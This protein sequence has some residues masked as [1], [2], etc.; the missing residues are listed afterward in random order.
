[1]ILQCPECGSAVAE[2][3]LEDSYDGVVCPVC[4]AFI[5]DEEEE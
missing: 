5:P 1:M 4:G 3:R 2:E